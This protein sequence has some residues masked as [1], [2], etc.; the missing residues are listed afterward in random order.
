LRRMLVELRQISLFP[1]QDYLIQI[2]GD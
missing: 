2:F 1:L